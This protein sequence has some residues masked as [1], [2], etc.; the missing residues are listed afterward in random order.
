MSIMGEERGRR[1]ICSA[2][3]SW[4]EAERESIDIIEQILLLSGLSKV[5]TNVSNESEL[6]V[7]AIFSGFFGEGKEN[8]RPGPFVK[9]LKIP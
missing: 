2:C 6:I 8:C 5:S 9:T 4:S 3:D 7:L 1:I